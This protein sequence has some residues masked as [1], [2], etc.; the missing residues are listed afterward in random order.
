M[1]A[2]V[3]IASDE[4]QIQAVDHMAQ[5]FRAYKQVVYKL[6]LAQVIS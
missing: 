2:V 3:R 5:L 6:L 4:V 1:P